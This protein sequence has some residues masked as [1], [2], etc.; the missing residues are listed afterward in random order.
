M[1]T[2]FQFRYN[3]FKTKYTAHPTNQ[4]VTVMCGNEYVCWF[5]QSEFQQMIQRGNIMISYE[6]NVL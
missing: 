6:E 1:N 3:G 4:T 2:P 5:E